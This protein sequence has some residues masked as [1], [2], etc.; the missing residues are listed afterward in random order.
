MSGTEIISDY[1]GLT[2]NEVTAY[3]VLKTPKLCLIIIND[4]LEK[5]FG[6]RGKDIISHVRDEPNTIK[7]VITKD[8]VIGNHHEANNQDYSE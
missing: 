1:K 2:R 8:K 6:I 4:A 3:M 7:L 5:K